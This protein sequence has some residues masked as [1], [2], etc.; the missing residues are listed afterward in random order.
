MDIS[1]SSAR[2]GGVRSNFPGS[3][4]SVTPNE[5]VFKVTLLGTY[6]FT[7]NDIISFEPNK[8][9]YGG[10][11]FIK[12]NVADYPEIISLNYKG[13][14]NELTRLLNQHG[15]IPSGI[16]DP[17]CFRKGISVRWVFLI[18][19]I[20]LWSV[21][22][23]FGEKQ[24]DT[25]YSIIA[26]AL[27]FAATIMIPKSETLQKL[28]LKP[29]RRVGEIVPILSLLKWISGILLAFSLISCFMKNI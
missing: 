11:I 16:S 9:L 24:Q 2:I 22:L 28:I 27:T 8:G 15:F 19:A 29:Y 21:L 18:A 23:F 6:K 14:A 4:L 10:N 25:I 7:P 17:S 12:H 3:K 5:L 1:I 26:I 13:G 20:L